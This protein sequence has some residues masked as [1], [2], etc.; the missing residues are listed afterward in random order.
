MPHNPRTRFLGLAT[1]TTALLEV[2]DE[3]RDMNGETLAEAKERRRRHHAEQEAA[4]LSE[5]ETLERLHLG[6]A[7]LYRDGE[8]LVGCEV[9]HGDLMF[10]AAAIADRAQESTTD[11]SRDAEAL[12]AEMRAQGLDPLGGAA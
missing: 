9:R 1:R 2:D 12:I 4:W 10:P 6:K 7:D 5:A 3:Q 8:L 11:A